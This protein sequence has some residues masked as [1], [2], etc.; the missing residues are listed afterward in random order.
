MTLFLSRRRLL[1]SL[2]ASGALFATLRSA[3]SQAADA[4]IRLLAYGD[5][6]IHGYGL[7][8]ED[9][10]PA[11][12]H[13]ALLAAG[14]AVVVV[15][16]G[17]SGDTSAAGL[18]RVD[19]TLAEGADCVLLC[20][21]ANDFLR[22]LEPAET[23]RNLEALLTRFQAEGLPVLLTGMVAPHNLGADYAAE[24]DSLYPELAE[25]FDATLYPFFL[26][27]VALDPA[28]NQQDGIHPNAAGVAV[29]VER[30]LPAVET[31]LARVE[32]GATP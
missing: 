10:F 9:T 20:L 13:A 29:I 7:A 1:A 4:P 22:G 3:P 11:Q 27:G 26:D 32:P 16:G 25:Q 5:S 6:L 28:L 15:N 2:T 14:H 8:P 19:W 31:L 24:F 12:L 21:G 30:I 18:A 23:R 17:N